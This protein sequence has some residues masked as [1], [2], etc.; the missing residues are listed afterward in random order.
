[1]SD[2]HGPSGEE[3]V[4]TVDPVS[5]EAG[6]ITMH[7]RGSGSS[8]GLPALDQASK[9]VVVEEIA[10]GGMGVIMRAVDRHVR[11]DVAMKV[12]A[13]DP[14]PGSEGERSLARAQERFV[15][16]AQ[17]TG[18][19]EHPNI[20]PIHEV[21]IDGEGRLFFTMK[22]VRGRSLA[23]V[24]GDLRRGMPRTK[25]EFGLARL[26]GIYLDIGNAVAF[27][28]ARGVVHRDLKPAN[29]M[30][31]DFG[32][33]L[34]MDWGLAR[35]GATRD[36]SDRPTKSA[37]AGGGRRIEATSDADLFGEDLKT[38]VASFQGENTEDGTV[39]GT[40]AYMPP[41]QARGEIAAIDERSDIYS[42]GAILYE[43]LCL[44][45]PVGG[46]DVKSI[47][48][49]VIAN[50][51]PPPETRAGDRPVP[52]ELS[53]IARKCLAGDP[54]RRY[55]SVVELR[56][57]I[58]RFLEGR[59]VSAKDDTAV[60][61]VV[62]LVR[63]NQ[64]AAI[65]TA[66]ATLL[67]VVLGATSWWTNLLERRNAEHQRELAE[68]ASRD[69]QAASLVAD[70]ERKRAQRS[71]A[72]LESE[73]LK[74]QE[75][76]RAAAPALVEQARRAIDRRF[77]DD[78]REF[79]DRALQYRPNLDDARLLRA[80]IMAATG[81]P[82]GAANELNEYLGRKADDQNK[83]PDLVKARELRDLCVR[84]ASGPSSALANAIADVL[85]R[86]GSR[87]LADHLL[88]QSKELMVAYRARLDAVWPKL[89]NDRFNMNRE[90]RIE[91]D[92][93]RNRKDVV[94][95]APL[96]GMPI[97][98][99][100]LNRTP[101]ADLSPIAGAP[102]EILD[103][104]ETKVVRLEPL[105]GMPLRVLR[106]ART[107]VVDLSPLAGMPLEELELYETPVVDLSPLASCPK[108]R[109][110]RLSQCKGVVDLTPL[111]GLPLEE[112]DISGSGV[113]SLAALSESKLRSLRA[114]SCPR[115]TSLAG[116]TGL[117]L[118]NL[119]CEGSPVTSLEP[120]RGLPL[121]SLGVTSTAITEVAALVG[122]KLAT[123]DLS[124][125]PVSDVTPL[126]DLDL[127]SLNL[128]GTAVTDLKGIVKL[129]LTALSLIGTRVAN[130]QPLSNMPLTSLD[131]SRTPVT[132]LRPLAKLPLTTLS[133]DGTPVTDL[134]P[135][136]G[137]VTLR[138]LNLA[139]TP[140]VRLDPL[141]GLGLTRIAVTP[142][143]L[144]PQMEVLRKI[145]KLQ[146][147][148]ALEPNET[149][150]GRQQQVKDFWKKWDEPKK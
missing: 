146:Q 86:L 70:A 4:A 131:L 21:G 13:R 95:L 114:Q 74:R 65:A 125:L 62:K 52:S 111:A 92:C 106:L 108:L 103:I 118:T 143:A 68:I 104:S 49:Q 45:P 112:L 97:I 80:Q 71:L 19:L 17:V 130:L 98:R 124:G 23:Q 96:A 28:H 6:T 142:K 94:D 85:Y 73:Q 121:R 2:R 37:S 10:R 32:E 58:E 123:L 87:A 61:A 89:S 140:V 133:L 69:A 36:S 54:E 59:A 41:E 136:R 30:L 40:P 141:L 127:A 107:Q 115:L 149:G 91:I 63:R 90:G 60:E 93:L 43:I 48:D 66:I 139:G 129:K 7:A 88:G 100:D 5:I 116:L 38:L 132:D 122:M 109:L 14:R 84:S 12:L 39:E 51:I 56:R 26:L 33:V 101:V 126:R 72:E 50:R 9:Y 102:L 135:L 147:I 27:A 83:Q 31:G 46:K 25:A 113:T 120:L 20:V 110:V 3:P 44:R 82:S 105:A 53:A 78:A 119:S 42:L 77:F 55:Q 16:E 148:A 35:V 128:N 134:E 138:E 57:D 117:P 75:D 76:Q 1:M 29:V 8:A 67:L 22:L 15:A 79:L 34:V 18:Q 144:G 99:L 11:R 81:D 137:L 150:W 145:E 47:L 24:L 64:G